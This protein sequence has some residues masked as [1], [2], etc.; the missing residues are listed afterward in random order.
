MAFADRGDVF[1]TTNT[2]A[3]PQLFV[4]A[5]GLSLLRMADIAELSELEKAVRL[6]PRVAA[7]VLMEDLAERLGQDCGSE[8]PV[9]MDLIA[10]MQSIV[11]I[12][13]TVSSYSGCLIHQDGQLRIE[14][15]ALDRPE[16]QRF[17]IGHEVCH[18]LLPSYTLERNFRCNP[19]ASTPKRGA[20]LN[21]EW[22]ADVGASELLLPRR[23]V[24]RTF[25]EQYGWDTIESVA[26]AYGASLEATAR[27]FVRL[28]PTPA[29][30]VNLM[31][32]S[33]RGKPAPELR[34]K[35][36]SSSPSLNL[37][38]PPNKSIPRD[39]PVFDASKG[40]D[41]DAVVD[42]RSLRAPGTWHAVARPYPINNSKGEPVMRVM[43]LGLQVFATAS[44]R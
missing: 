15:S 9:Q 43:V 28:S 19:G 20:Q 36:S 25:T 22:L 40:E 32:A 4:N 24:R 38:I 6:H 33:S 34:V 29:I 37:F 1:A 21:V 41:V 2:L 5:N 26:S 39:H 16:R 14:V 3:C 12:I 31:F 35:S 23:Y 42:M 8:P 44:S 27:R 18:T 30:F 13:E 10:S 7:D 17:T 11:E